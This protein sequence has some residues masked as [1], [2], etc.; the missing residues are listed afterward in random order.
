MNLLIPAETIPGKSFLMFKL[1]IS[2]CGVEVSHRETGELHQRGRERMAPW[3]LSP[4]MVMLI[5]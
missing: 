2:G 5:T 3:F 1:S 4:R